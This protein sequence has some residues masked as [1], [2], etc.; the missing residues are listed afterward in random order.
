M[1]FSK[2]YL[3]TYRGLPELLEKK[4]PK[5]NFKNHCYLRMA[6]DHMFKTR[7][8]LRVARPAHKHLSVQQKKEIVLILRKY[9]K[10]K[11]L[12][13]EHHKQS[14]TIRKKCRKKQLKLSL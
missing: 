10:L 4:Y 12:V 13:L 14:I 5:L 6:L 2:G 8:D 1:Q 11:S 3:E 7:W 9:C